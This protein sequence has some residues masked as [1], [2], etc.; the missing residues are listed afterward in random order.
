MKTIVLYASKSGA[1]KECAQLLAEKIP[2]A[3][4]HSV[5]SRT[6][7][8]EGYDRIVLGSGVRM[9]KI[10]K[11]MKKYMEKNLDALMAKEVVLYLCN[12]YP[13]TFEKAVKSIPFELRQAA[14]SIASFGGKPPFIKGKDGDDGWLNHESID[15]F[16]E[17][18]S[19]H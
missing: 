3:E 13:D 11:A 5:A 10:Y 7:D 19:D 14:L 9:G 16:V 1:A 15:R 17:K 4:C 8:L 18:L 6:P 12:G 2:E